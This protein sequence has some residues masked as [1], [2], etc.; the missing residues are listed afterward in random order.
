MNDLMELCQYYDKEFIEQ[1][2][3]WF[4]YLRPSTDRLM[5]DWRKTISLLEKYKD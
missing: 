2:K 4:W 3:K 5:K 1:S